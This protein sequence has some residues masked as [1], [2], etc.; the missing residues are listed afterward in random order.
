MVYSLDIAQAQLKRLCHAGFESD[1]V[2][3]LQFLR[4]TEELPL[5]SRNGISEAAYNRYRHVVR[6]VQQ[7]K[8]YQA[9]Y[10][11]SPVRSILS[12]AI[13]GESGAN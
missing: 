8:R 10:E 2:D 11:N 4:R 12:I 3:D 13:Y 6:D 9:Y 7:E 1:K 5:N